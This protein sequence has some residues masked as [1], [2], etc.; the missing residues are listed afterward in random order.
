MDPPRSASGASASRRCAK[1]TEA[2]GDPRAKGTESAGIACAGAS[3]VHNP[4]M[5]LQCSGCA[6]ALNTRCSDLSRSLPKCA[7][8]NAVMD[9][10][11]REGAAAGGRF[12]DV[13][14][15]EVRLPERFVTGKDADG[16]FI[17]WRWF[18]PQH[19]LLVLFALG[20]NGSLL[21]FFSMAR[22]M[23]APSFFFLVPLIHVAIGVG[24]G[25]AALT[26][27]V[28]STTVRTGKG[29]LTI[30][31]RPLPWLGNRDLRGSGID[32]LYCASKV[33]T[34]DG[35]STTAYQLRAVLKT[36]KTLTL[37]RG[38]PELEQALFLEQRIERALGIKD[39]PEAGEV[40]R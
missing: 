36:G 22:S 6:A 31:H 35:R 5:R 15:P 13:E 23:D 40:P 39:Q 27:L 8:C 29:I 3:A 9:L 18:R 24:I 25:Y 4:A 7:F 2:R 11:R 17:R 21:F 38:L 37:L 34:N 32:Q 1:S 16:A 19:L 14:R 10:G 33:T 20:W 28:N 26:G 12:A 30:R